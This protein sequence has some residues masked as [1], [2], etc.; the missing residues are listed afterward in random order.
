M[1][2]LFKNTKIKAKTNLWIQI[3]E[4][5]EGSR[6]YFLSHLKSSYK[7]LILLYYSFFSISFSLFYFLIIYVC[8]KIINGNLM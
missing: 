7:T 1:V 4:K 2:F 6:I 3:I 5:N 8:L